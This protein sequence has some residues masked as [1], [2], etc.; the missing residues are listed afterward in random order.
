LKIKVEFVKVKA[1]ILAETRIGA[2]FPGGGLRGAIPAPR[3]HPGG[4]IRCHEEVVTR[5]V[6]DRGPPVRQGGK[7]RREL[8]P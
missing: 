2:G 4:A 7:N 3:L 6:P 5:F 8:T 1:Y